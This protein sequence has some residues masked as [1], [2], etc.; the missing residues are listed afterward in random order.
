MNQFKYIFYV[1][2]STISSRI[3]GDNVM[4][5]AELI[6]SELKFLEQWMKS[7]K[8]TSNNDKMKF[9]VFSYSKICISP[10]SR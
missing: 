2:D 8:I 5:S 6:N 9:M 3:P 4:E 1:N 10:L 7:N